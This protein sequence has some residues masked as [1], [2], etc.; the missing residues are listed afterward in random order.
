MKTFTIPLRKGFAKAPRYK[1]TNRAV[2]E[3]RTYLVRHMK[4]ENISIGKELNEF[5]WNHGVKNPPPRVKVHA[6]ED[7]GKV[8]VNLE[9]IK[10]ETSKDKEA[11][12]KKKKPVAKEKLEDTVEKAAEKKVEKPVEKKEEKPSEKKVE[13]KPKAPVPKE[14][15]TEKKAEPKEEKKE[16]HQPNENKN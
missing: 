9:S 5:L 11:K 15:V 14:Q 3:L 13:E 6:V 16:H 1:K 2:S 10:I 8:L 7:E 12:E 4:N